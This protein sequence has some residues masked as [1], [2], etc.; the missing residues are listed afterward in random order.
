MPSGIFRLK[1]VATGYKSTQ[2]VVVLTVARGPY[3][4]VYIQVGA[5]YGCHGAVWC[6]VAALL[7]SRATRS[8]GAH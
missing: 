7:R 6:E 4:Q 2:R 1:C 8:P 3:G 5:G